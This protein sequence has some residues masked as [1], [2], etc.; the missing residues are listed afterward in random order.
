MTNTNSSLLNPRGLFGLFGL[1]AL[2]CLLFLSLSQVK[3]RQL[4]AV[5]ALEILS[6]ACLFLTLLLFLEICFC[7]CWDDVLD[8][9]LQLDEH[10]ASQRIQKFGC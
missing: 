8:C 7:D 5:L 1:A 10:G 9:L 2:F 4:A 6:V 3:I